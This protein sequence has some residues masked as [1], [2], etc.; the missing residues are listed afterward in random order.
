MS[1]TDK[2]VLITG[3]S[4]GIGAACAVRFAKSSALLSL[5]GRNVDNLRDIAR[6]CEECSGLKPI[7]IT[8]D[9]TSDEDVERLVNQ[10]MNHYGRV[11]VLINNAGTS[12]IAESH[13]KITAYDN[14]M[15][16]NV[17]GTYLL[18]NEAIPHLIKSSGNIV[19]ISSILSTKPLPILTAYCMS[20][21]AI[22]MFTKCAALE[23]GAHGVRVNAVNPGPVKTQLFRRSGMSD[24]DTDRMFTSIELNS[25]LRKVTKSEDVAEL[26]LFLASDKANCITGSCYVID[27]GVNLG[28]SST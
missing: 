27:C 4:S 23:L 9:I 16:T 7:I 18:T 20:K 13:A 28:D 15:S 6:Q 25:P 10:T 8:A 22:D 12:S 11:D 24:I 1:F 3:A 19:N 14:V 21:A 5:I 26:V 17:R 2:V